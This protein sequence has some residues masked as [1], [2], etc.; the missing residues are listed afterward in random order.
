MLAR[1]E[2]CS[3]NTAVPS[4]RIWTLI[5]GCGNFINNELWWKLDWYFID[6]FSSFWEVRCFW[7]KS[8]KFFFSVFWLLVLLFCEIHQFFF[9]LFEDLIIFI[10]LGLE[11]RQFIIVCFP[12]TLSTILL[13]LKNFDQEEKCWLEISL[14]VIFII[15]MLRGDS[16]HLVLNVFWSELF[17]FYVLFSLDFYELFFW[18]FKKI[19]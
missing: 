10:K 6:N 11:V 8:K 3:F 18:L 16:K 2:F 17:W 9:Y 13:V 14:K 7:V 19:D 4:K 12:W 15:W 1:F 5:K